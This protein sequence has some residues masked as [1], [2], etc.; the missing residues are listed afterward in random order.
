MAFEEDYIMRQIKAAGEIGGNLVA[1]LLR[2]NQSDINW[3]FFEN[4]S[5]EKIS[6]KTYL[7]SLIQQERYHEAF[8]F[9]NSLKLKLAYYEFEMISMD[10]LYQQEQ[11]APETKQQHQI[12]TEKINE[13][14][15]TFQALL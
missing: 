15:E 6:R 1:H 13:Y 14:R 2:L 9:I 12:T 5:G 11:L 7:Q 4:E 8:V 3:V 10:F